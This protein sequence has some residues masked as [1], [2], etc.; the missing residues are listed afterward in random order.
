MK[1]AVGALDTEP[2][3]SKGS[4][5]GATR[6][7]HHVDAGRREASAKIAA[8]ATAADDGDSHQRILQFRAART[9]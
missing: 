8:E 7:E 4:E 5:V 9:G 3:G 1:V 2:A 6:Q